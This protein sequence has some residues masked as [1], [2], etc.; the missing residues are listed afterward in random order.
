MLQSIIEKSNLSTMTVT[1]FFIVVA[2][3]AAAV[4]VYN[5]Q[6]YIYI[7]TETCP[8]CQLYG[9]RWCTPPTVDVRTV[10]RQRSRRRSIGDRRKFL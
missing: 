10:I 9:D 4:A 3:V 6:Y 5:K 2:L 1:S 8:W 7:T